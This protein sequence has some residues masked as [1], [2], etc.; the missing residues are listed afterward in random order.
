MAKLKFTFRTLTHS[1]ERLNVISAK[2]G[3]TEREGFKTGTDVGKPMAMGTIPGTFA[4]AAAGAEIEGFL[5]NVDAGGTTD[6]FD[7]GGVACGNRGL[8]YHAEIEGAANLFDLVVAGD[9]AT[10]G[11]ANASGLG[12]VKVGEPKL[13]IWRIIDI[14]GGADT[15]TGGETVTLELL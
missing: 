7:F 9:N 11:E 8:R 10:A 4:I 3:A 6:G 5:D 13:H 15:A 14:A 12:K 2:L 1:P